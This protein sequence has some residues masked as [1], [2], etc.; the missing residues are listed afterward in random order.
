MIKKQYAWTCK[1]SNMP[2]L[3]FFLLCVASGMMIADK[4]YYEYKYWWFQGTLMLCI[5]FIAMGVFKCGR[6]RSTKLEE[7]NAAEKLARPVY[8]QKISVTRNG[9]LELKDPAEITVG[10]KLSLGPDDVVPCDCIIYSI[11]RGNNV[12]VDEKKVSGEV[13]TQSKVSTSHFQN[14]SLSHETVLFANSRIVAGDCKAFAIAV[15]ENSSAAIALKSIEREIR[16][17]YENDLLDTHSW[18]T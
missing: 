3:Y 9:I 6:V 16:E 2:L 11:E 17:R 10:D 15:G 7:Q 1:F 12:M 5:V 4:K 14:L 13:E 8:D 18:I